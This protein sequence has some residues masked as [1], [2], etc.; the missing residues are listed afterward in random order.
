MG[1]CVVGAAVLLVGLGAGAAYP[2][3][4]PAKAK[5]GAKDVSVAE[6]F[7]SGEWT[8]TGVDEKKGL[9]HLSNGPGGIEGAPAGPAVIPT[10]DGPVVAGFL[11]SGLPLG[12]AAKLT[13]DGK[14]AKVGDLKQGMIVKVQ[15]A[16]DSLRVSKLEA[17]SQ[18]KGQ[19]SRGPSSLWTV[20]A[21]DSKKKTLTVTNASLGLT[22]KDLAVTEE[23]QAQVMGTMT[24]RADD[25]KLGELK[26]G[27]SVALG[28][29]VDAKAGTFV[30][31]L[32][33]A[34]S[35]K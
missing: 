20:K 17:A 2:G 26:E 7:G 23:T 28:F 33:A 22:V 32:L 15:L 16:K 5:A 31:D 12:E 25:L 14:P 30:L 11:V 10:K 18:T 1:G 34:G 19:A 27:T 8:L 6:V 21:T 4:E 35:D 13:L 9:V 24:L 29:R 3:D